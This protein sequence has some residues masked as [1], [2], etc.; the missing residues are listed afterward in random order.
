[1]STTDTCDDTNL[2][3][4][5]GDYL[6]L[7]HDLPD[8]QSSGETAAMHGVGSFIYDRDGFYEFT[9]I[10]TNPSTKPCFLISFKSIYMA[11]DGER[12][13]L[14]LSYAHHFYYSR[15]LAYP[16]STL[17]DLNS[18]LSRTQVREAINNYIKK[19]LL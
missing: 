12:Y 7:A 8:Y 19:T 1:M 15:F 2:A 11:T 18:S 4:E 17:S 3:L 10:M 6:E 9:N 5:G 13:I 16:N 14:L